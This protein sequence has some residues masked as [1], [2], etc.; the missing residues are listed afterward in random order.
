MGHVTGHSEWKS[1][2][3]DPRVAVRAAWQLALDEG[4]WKRAELL[5][6]LKDAGTKPTEK[7]ANVDTDAGGGGDGGDGGGGGDRG[8]IGGS[9]AGSRLIGGDACSEVGGESR[10]DVLCYRPH[11]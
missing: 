9:D 6:R 2:T 8:G 11:G 1:L 10:R 5:E 3:A 7:R 4:Q